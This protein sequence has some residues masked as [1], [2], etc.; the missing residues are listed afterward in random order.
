MLT[1][2]LEELFTPEQLKAFRER[3]AGSAAV[4]AAH[5]RDIVRQLTNPTDKEAL[6]AEI[7]LCLVGDEPDVYAW[8]EAL[9]VGSFELRPN[10]KYA[11]HGKRGVQPA[12]FYEDQRKLIEGVADRNLTPEQKRDW[13]H[14]YDDALKLIVASQLLHEMRVGV[15]AKAALGVAWPLMLAADGKRF[16]LRKRKLLHLF[17]GEPEFIERLREAIE[18]ALQ[19]WIEEHHGGHAPSVRHLGDNTD[20]LPG[21]PTPDEILA[22]VDP[23]AEA[24]GQYRVELFQQLDMPSQDMSSKLPPIKPHEIAAL[25]AAAI[26]S[27]IQ[28]AGLH[29]GGF[30]EEAASFTA[31]VPHALRYTPDDIRRLHMLLPILSDCEP[32]SPHFRAAVMRARKR[33]E[34][35]TGSSTLEADR[36]IQEQVASWVSSGFP[37]PPDLRAEHAAYF[38]E[39]VCL[40]DSFL[41][42]PWHEDWRQLGFSVPVGLEEVDL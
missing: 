11:H 12:R 41:S 7:V 39:E 18:A 29:N 42:A 8:T 26:Q 4:S 1:L 22:A 34:L 20:T 35:R 23:V 19:V 13:R 2:G 15:A 25:D 37:P 9:A 17:G 3:W 28:I 38:E 14:A 5:A 10:V 32:A 40:H 27:A 36:R 24:I 6:V 21:Q 16:G 33:M 30:V 31:C